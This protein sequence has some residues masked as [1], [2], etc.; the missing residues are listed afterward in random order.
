MTLYE[1]HRC[2]HERREKLRNKQKKTSHSRFQKGSFPYSGT[3]HTPLHH[4]SLREVEE[5]YRSPTA[6]ALREMKLLMK[7]I[8]KQ[9]SQVNQLINRGNDQATGGG[10]LETAKRA[11]EEI[12]SCALSDRRE[13]Q[14]ME[15]LNIVSVYSQFY[16]ITPYV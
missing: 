6:C 16:L 13:R 3:E 9:S 10:S 14:K 15:E 1:S 11:L 2:M 8:N 12:F 7:N 5:T 4:V